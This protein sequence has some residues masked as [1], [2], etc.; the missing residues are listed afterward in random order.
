VKWIQRIVRASFAVVEGELWIGGLPVTELAGRFGTPLFVYDAAVLDGQLEQLRAALPS[1]FEVYYSVK[2]NPNPWILRHFL[3]RGCGLEVASAGEY[4][5]ARLAG[6]PSSRILFAGP[7][8][9]RA[10]LELV[11]KEGLGELHVESCAELARVAEVA[12]QLRT[13]VAVAVRVNPGPSAAGGAL[14]MG[15]KPT[16]FG[17]DEEL[18]DEAV[19]RVRRMPRLDFTGIHLFT[20]TQILDAAVLGRQYR[21]AVAIARRLAQRL[22]RPLRTVDL[23]GGLGVPYTERDAPLDLGK[24]DEELASLWREVA[25]DPCFENTRFILE[26]GR[27]L[28]GPAGVY[29]TRVIEVKVSRGRT[30]VITDGGMHHH[31][32][33]SGQLGQVLRRNFPVAIL[34]KL[35]HSPEIAADVVGPL[36][37]P[38]DV[39]ARGLEL[40][41]PTPGDLIG[42]FQ[43]GAYARA[44]SPLHFLSHPTPPEVLVGNGVAQLIRRRGTL[45][46]L[47]YDIP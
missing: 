45:D 19:A 11:L 16:A 12:E 14:Q 24:F 9:T 6:C 34:T 27:F 21:A 10:E 7:G 15:G 1:A 36:C 28:V 30:F 5:L 22:G 35:D 40:P 43:S 26:P 41:P 8:K 31:L 33:A 2:A 47:T 42:V 4:H 29:V 20:G 32:A 13:S 46:D 38:L 25:T 23:G 18:L 44:A 17:V 3:A 37:T 39:L